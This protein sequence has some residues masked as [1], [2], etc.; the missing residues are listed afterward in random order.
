MSQPSNQQLPELK[1][2]C[3][4]ANFQQLKVA[5]LFFFPTKKKKN[6]FGYHLRCKTLQFKLNLH[7][8][9]DHKDACDRAKGL[10]QHQH[11][12]GDN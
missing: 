3:K 4:S 11:T 9:P 12:T 7:V 6:D 10:S 5:L 1:L 2:E 8:N